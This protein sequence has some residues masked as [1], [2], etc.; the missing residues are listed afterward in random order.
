M[1]WSDTEIGY[2]RNT[3]SNSWI[4][5][6]WQ[7]GVGS[8]Q[9]PVDLSILPRELVES[10]YLHSTFKNNRSW[11]KV[12]SEY[13]THT[14]TSTQEQKNKEYTPLCIQIHKNTSTPVH[15]KKKY[16][17]LNQIQRNYKNINNNSVRLKC[18]ERMIKIIQSGPDKNYLVR[19]R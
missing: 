3:D 2:R 9:S 18:F 15:I 4:G 8:D 16:R 7:G 17:V 19:I 10:I 12:L 1:H 5:Y 11:R 13:T 14:N 6:L